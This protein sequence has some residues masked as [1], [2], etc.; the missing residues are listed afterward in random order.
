LGR[1]VSR[2]LLIRSAQISM[3]GQPSRLTLVSVQSAA[4]D[5]TGTF[6][7]LVRKRPGALLVA[8]CSSHYNARSLIVE[9]AAQ[10]RL[11]TMYFSRECVDAG[12]L[13]SYGAIFPT[14]SDARQAR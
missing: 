2:E 6:A 12:G 5:Y 10:S 3:G 8:G 9:F 11:P 13:I 7:F 4:R 1:L 14:F